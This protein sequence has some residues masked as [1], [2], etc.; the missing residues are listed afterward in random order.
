MKS[1]Q[2][3]LYICNCIFQLIIPVNTTHII[4]LQV[5]QLFTCLS[6]LLA[7]LLVCT[8]Q[9]D[10]VYPW[11]H[12]KHIPMEI[13]HH[14]TI[15]SSGI[16]TCLVTMQQANM[17]VRVPQPM[18]YVTGSMMSQLYS[19]QVSRDNTPNCT[20]MAGEMRNN[21]LFIHTYSYK[22][23]TSKVVFTIK[24]KVSSSHCKLSYTITPTI[25]VWCAF[26]QSN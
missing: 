7:S 8:Q 11:H 14:M 23:W 16:S 18:K 17:L 15:T 21:L 25:D 5:F 3:Q 20:H 24:T 1:P 6:L 4:T 13:Q 9:T 19:H 22:K 2:L 12:G 26:N 10:I